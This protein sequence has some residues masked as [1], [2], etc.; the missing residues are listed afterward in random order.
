MT[1]QIYLLFVP[2]VHYHQVNNFALSHSYKNGGM[3]VWENPRNIYWVRVINTVYHARY[4]LT[5]PGW[6]I[7]IYMYSKNPRITT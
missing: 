3:V 5:E 4:K 1:L 6:K 2:E 7:P